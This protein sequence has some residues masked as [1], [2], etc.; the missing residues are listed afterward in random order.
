MARLKFDELVTALLLRR[1]ELE[2]QAEEGDGRYYACILREDGD[3]LVHHPIGPQIAPPQLMWARAVLAALNRE[4]HHDGAWVIVFTHPRPPQLP[5][6]L[7]LPN[8]WDYRR[9]AILWLDED[10]DPQFTMEWQEQHTSDLIDFAAVV[11]QGLEAT[12]TK[13]EGCW[14]AWHMAMRQVIEPKPDQLFKRARGERAP[15]ARH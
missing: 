9:Y 2:A 1:F 5:H 13:A 14:Q 4:L 6:V 11:A 12:L 10:A 15:S 7:A 8:H 3:L